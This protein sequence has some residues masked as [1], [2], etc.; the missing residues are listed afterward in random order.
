MKLEYTHNDL[1]ENVRTVAVA[2][3]NQQLVDALDLGLQAKQAH[4]NVKGPQFISLHELFDDVAEAIEEICDLVAERAVQLG[5]IAE[6]TVDVIARNSRLPEYGLDL[7][8]GTDHVR[9]LTGA[10][11]RFA[12]S[13]REAITSATDAGDAD[14]ADIFTQAS[15][16]ADTQLWKVSSHICEA[17]E[18]AEPGSVTGT[19]Q[20]A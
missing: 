3:L 5:G 7:Y 17:W 15:R 8:R 2:L 4:W 12:A 9:A 16:V 1:P 18:R 14:T 13:V 20:S 19:A 6:G 11:A 10:L